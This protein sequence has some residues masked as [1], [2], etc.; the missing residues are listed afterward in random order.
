M[1]DLG[2]IRGFYRT[3]KVLLKCVGSS[4]RR[5]AMLT[6]NVVGNRRIVGLFRR[7]CGKIWNAMEGGQRG[8]SLRRIN[9]VTGTIL[10]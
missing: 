9:S 6:M 7:L 8:Q 5:F 4:K 2:R 3:G 10:I 1:A